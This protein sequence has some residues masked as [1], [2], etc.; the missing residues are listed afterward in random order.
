MYCT[1]IH[2]DPKYNMP[3]YVGKGTLDR[4]LAHLMPSKGKTRIGNLL[5]KRTREGYSIEPIVIK[6]DDELTAIFMERFWIGVIGREDKGLGPLFN[7]T[8]GGEGTAGREPWNKGKAAPK[9]PMTEQH[10]SNIVKANKGNPNLGLNS[11]ATRR[12]RYGV[13]GRPLKTL[14]GE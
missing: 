4:P 9:P 11:W 7:L 1:Y 8:D 13:S 5:R 14:E 2:L 10:I 12:A 3:R 6:T